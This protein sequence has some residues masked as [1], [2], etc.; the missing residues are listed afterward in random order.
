[1]ADGITAEALAHRLV[2]AVP[3]P[4]ITSVTGGPGIAAVA[5]VA[6]VRLRCP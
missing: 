1:V 4:R 3:P 5:S 2:E 6:N